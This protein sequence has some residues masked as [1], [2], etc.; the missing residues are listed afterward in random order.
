[1]TR[2][3]SLACVALLL[4]ATPSAGLTGLV[5]ADSRL[6]EGSGP[7]K[8]NAADVGGHSIEQAQNN[9]IT[10]LHKYQNEPASVFEVLVKGYPIELGDG[11]AIFQQKGN[12][13]KGLTV[14]FQNVSNKPISSLEVHVTANNPAKSGNLID[15]SL[16]FGQDPGA[17]KPEG[18]AVV[19]PGQ[20]AEL[21]ISDA[22]YGR[23]EHVLKGNAGGSLAKIRIVDI[24]LGYIYFDDDTAWHAGAFLRPDPDHPGNYMV[25]EKQGL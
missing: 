8:A 18:A 24:E 5:R 19:G 10:R 9:A 22:W 21:S 1:M 7:Y 16:K 23:A 3:F 17:N 12:W 14:R 13:L 11:A 6:S 20:V 25:I 15:F 4:A 2:S